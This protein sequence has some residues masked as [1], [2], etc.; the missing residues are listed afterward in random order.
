MQMTDELLHTKW[1]MIAED[2]VG[3]SKYIPLPDYITS[4]FQLWMHKE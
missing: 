3:M 4:L 2:M 1:K